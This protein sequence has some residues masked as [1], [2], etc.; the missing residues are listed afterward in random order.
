[1]S[2]GNRRLGLG[3]RRRRP[4]GAIEALEGRVL[5]A[6]STFQQ[7]VDGYA[8]AA[9][10]E[11]VSDAPDTTHGSDPTHIV[12][13]PS[14]NPEVHVLMRFGDVFGSGPGQVPDGAVIRSATV[15]VTTTDGNGPGDGGTLHQML[16]DWQPASSWNSLTGGVQPDGVE[17]AADYNAQVGA[18]G[19]NQDPAAL[20][21]FGIDVTQ[22][23]QSWSD[24]TDPN[25]ANKGWAFLGWD[26]RTNGWILYSSEFG[27]EADRPEL[28][29]DW[30]IPADQV[31]TASFQDGA[32]GYAGTVDT[33]L[34]QGDPTADAGATDPL[35]IDWP[36][37]GGTNES[38]V[39][40]RFDDIIGPGA[41][42]VP[43]GATII[44]AQLRLNTAYEVP[45]GTP[46]GDGAR[47]YRMIQGWDESSTWD[48][49]VGG[50]QADGTEARTEFVSSAGD[51][52]GSPNVT[53]A[54]RS[55]DVTADLQAWADGETNLG[56]AFLGWE[57]RTDG[58][59][60]TSSENADPSLRPQ[61]IVQYV[62]AAA[63][64][65]QVADLAPTP[66]GFVATFNRPIDPTE[67]NLYNP[68]GNPFGPADATLVGAS[69][70]AARGSLVVAPDGRSVTFVATGGLLPADTYTVTLRSGADAFQDPA[71][72]SLDGNAD[73]SDG[74]DYTTS[75]TTTAP[76]GRVV[77]LPDF[78]RGAGQPVDVP[79]VAAG[80]PIAVSDADG[81][82]KL[83]AELADDPTLLT[84]TAA[85][86]APGLPTGSAVA[87]EAIPGGIRLTF[88]SPTPLSAG[89]SDLIVL[90][91]T[92]PD[93]APYGTKEVLDLRNLQIND[94]AIAAVDDDAVHAAAYLGDAS[95]A[96]GTPPT[97]G[98]DSFD[99][100]LALGLAVGIDGGLASYRTL[101]PRIVADVTGDGAV[102]AFDAG[103]ILSAAIGVPTPQI[104]RP[105][106][107]VTIVPGGVAP[108]IYLPR[109]LAAAPGDRLVVPVL[110]RQTDP[111]GRAV[112]LRG[113]DLV[114]GIDP[115]AFRIVN[116]TAGDLAGGFGV[117]WRSADGLLHVGLAGASA[118]HLDPGASGRWP[119]SNWR[120]WP[121]RRPGPRR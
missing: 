56:W 80:L 17:A 95:G 19:G 25:A 114:L 86:I 108:M 119:S 79:A 89:P 75:F 118:V 32:D 36:D 9:D 88:T 111:L 6:T 1:M 67:L 21:R 77:R 15:Y 33:Q 83:V 11:L 115:S 10:T 64:T 48:G 12:D 3:G 117:A 20:V 30:Y 16:T 82:T 50:V 91:A 49:L 84:I 7:G 106:A 28:Q 59:F 42:Q 113:I 24:A 35:L 72:K 29:V 102:D 31:S 65:L 2:A 18:P 81:I 14:N 63:P 96:Q 99:A 4:R 69:T 105:P 5:L 98:I 107:G 43:A 47:F 94:G 41:G 34:N 52:G 116:V 22:D 8:A 103:L 62:M 93:S 45:G 71:G 53:S 70:G 39:L 78:A 87:M 37:A 58:W 112:D 13:F 55:F 68:A 66:T 26:S 51:P 90:T 97:A 101:D 46:G 60:I 121:T 74:G 44:N 23:L 54:D 109:D 100:G 120:C 61:L 40:L 104:P 110:F 92:V 76:A 27:Q 57:G 38:Q 85:D 73:G